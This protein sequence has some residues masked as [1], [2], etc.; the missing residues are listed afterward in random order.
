MILGERGDVAAMD[1]IDEAASEQGSS[2]SN[3]HGVGHESSR[4]LVQRVPA[5][6]S[7]LTQQSHTVLT[8]EHVHSYTAVRRQMEREMEV[9][10]W[11]ENYQACWSGSKRITES[12]KLSPCTA[13]VKKAVVC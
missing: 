10:R 4:A 12:K 11:V 9:E 3:K 5:F 8:P 7:A 1:G 13:V 6:T 2:K